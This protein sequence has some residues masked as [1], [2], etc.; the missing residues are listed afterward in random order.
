MAEHN[1]LGKWGEDEAALY[2]EDRGYEILE[3]DWKVGKRDIDLIALTED[4]DTLVFVEVKTRQN[5]DLQEP[6]EAVDVKKMRNL[7][8]AA[9]AYVKLHGLDMDVRFDIISVIGKCSCV[10]SIECFEDAFNP[11]LIL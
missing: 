5:N 4:K 3:R 11:L 6:E 9:N 2:Y 1:D 10:E 8:I 7:A